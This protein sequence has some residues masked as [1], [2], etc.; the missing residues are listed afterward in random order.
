[1]K[2]DFNIV[3][4]FFIFF[5]CCF[6][7]RCLCAFRISKLMPY[8]QCHCIICKNCRRS[9]YSCSNHCRT[10]A[11]SCKFFP[12]VHSLFSSFMIP[13]CVTYCYADIIKSR[14][15]FLNSDYLPERVRFLLLYS[16]TVFPVYF[17][18]EVPK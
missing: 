1:M 6:K 13:V 4:F 16:F 10:H 3:M 7:C 2:F 17:L 18:K 14:R 8:I 9:K 5:Y 15:S 12:F 11:G